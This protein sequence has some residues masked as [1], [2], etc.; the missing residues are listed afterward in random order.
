MESVNKQKNINAHRQFISSETIESCHST[1]K[2]E[3]DHFV[4]N[5]MSENIYMYFYFL[6][7]LKLNLCEYY[8]LWFYT[9]VKLFFN[10]F[11]F[12]ETPL[13]SVLANTK[14]IIF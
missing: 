4:L 6:L 9:T 10:L 11:I 7:N 1:A 3:F 2:F 14:K 8:H 13:K 5:V 12:Q